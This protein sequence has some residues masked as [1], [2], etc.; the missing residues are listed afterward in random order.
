VIARLR[1][2]T[3]LLV[4]LVPSSLILG[5]CAN[6]RDPTIRRVNNDEALFWRANLD[7]MKGQY[8]EAREQLRTLVTQ[9]PES[10]LI[11]EARLGIARTYFQEEHYEQ[12]RAE[13]ERFLSL[14]PRHERVDE[15]LYYVGLTYFR[16]IERPDRDQ[17]AS[18]RAVVA[19]R[20]LLSEVPD[21]QYREDA[22]AKIAVARRRL[23]THEMDVGL[24]YLK[25]DKF[26][27]AVGR[28]QGVIDRYNGTGLEPM[29]FFYLGETYAKMEE[30]EKAQDAF[31]QLLEK[32][33]D[34]LWAVVAGDRLGVKVVLQSRPAE[35]RKNSDEETG[36]IWDLFKESWEDIKATFKHSLKPTPE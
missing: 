9:F 17:T 3:V 32:Y 12:A 15:A 7:F 1:A 29:A 14:Y 10:P 4:L 13:Y 36:G 30:K 25:R 6:S 5:S 2:R 27:G 24:F 23:A 28:F 33:P 35:D 20:K 34:S 19:F 22:E 21:T 11:P 26:T 18:R 31:R 16:Q 8:E